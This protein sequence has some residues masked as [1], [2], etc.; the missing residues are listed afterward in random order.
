MADLKVIIKALF[1]GSDEIDKAKGQIEGLGGAAEEMEKVGSKSFGDFQ[2]NVAIA[3]LGINQAIEVGMKIAEAAQFA[4]ENTVGK[5]L[6][7][8][9]EIEE[10][11]RISGEAPENMSALRVA[12]EES[13]VPFDDLYKAMENL[14]KNGVAPTVDNLVAI[15]DEYVN[16]QDPIEKAALLTENFGTAGDGIASMLEDIAGGVKAVDN[17]GLIFTEE[18]IQQV[19]DYETAVAELGTAW[20]GLATTVGMEVIPVL[21]DI[22]NQISDSS[23]ISF[24]R[25]QLNGVAQAALDAGYITKTEYSGIMAEAYDRSKTTGEAVEYLN[26]A[27]DDLNGVVEGAR[28]PA[29]AAMNAHDDLVMSIFNGSKSW[30]DF[31]S[32]MDAAGI[33]MGMLTKDI[34][35]AEK[36]FGDL[37]TAI[38]K[39]PGI[40]TVEVELTVDDSKIRNYIPPTKTGTVVYQTNRGM[41][42][43][44]GGSVNAGNTYTWQ[45]Y[46]YRGEVFVPS[47]DGFVL[48]RAD[49]ERA[50]A[51]ALYGGGSAVDPAAIG[52][53]VA[54]AMSGVTAKGK[55]GNVYNLTMPTSNN[56]AD[57][58]TAF[59]LMEAWGA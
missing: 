40:K 8:A 52:K 47:A 19:N 9:G 18:E 3:M 45:E 6:D 27:I 5:A 2:D 13:K 7:I 22:F 39:V 59:E 58:R 4:Y 21:T 12:A 11:S 44:V 20:D 29:V 43:A 23:S 25:E 28:A 14:N 34:Y 51:R 37:N 31:S 33:D 36:G 17:A 30:E 46:G 38:E 1:E 55:G 35:N 54:Q 53:A 32:K 41:E 57:V 48:S 50:L 24:L 16:L 42:Y 49:A 26:S 56:P 15:A 10:L